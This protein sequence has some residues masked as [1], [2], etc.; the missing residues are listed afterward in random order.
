[1]L[2]IL[3]LIAL[4]TA[5]VAAP[6]AGQVT[7]NDAAAY[8]SLVQTPVGALAPIATSTLLDQRQRG[9]VFAV[10]YGYIA[11]DGAVGFNN[12][13]ATAVLPMGLQS[14]ISLTAGTIIPTC[15]DQSGCSS[16]LMLGGGG[17]MRLTSFDVATGMRATLSLN[18]ELGYGKPRN[19][20]YAFSGSVGV[21]IAVTIAATAPGMRIVPF[22]TPA[23]GFG[24]E[25]V[26]L[27]NPGGTGT[28][29][30]GASG[31]RFIIGGGIA[32]TNPASTIGANL[33]FQHVVFEG[34]K[35]QVG[36]TV[37]FGGR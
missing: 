20:D 25:Q 33:G 10:R 8:A 6:V 2:L 16:G 22:I 9:A 12:L 28:F 23:F 35:T 1:M 3:L 34:G 36:I 5:P 37:T 31:Q 30:R 4:V 21:P 27:D 32:L 14:T 7:Q 24:N 29:S 15:H 26:T 17:D 13:G 18:G 19:V 11:T